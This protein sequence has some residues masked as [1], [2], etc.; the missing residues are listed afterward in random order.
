MVISVFVPW[1]WSAPAF[2]AFLLGSFSLLLPIEQTYKLSREHNLLGGLE[3]THQALVYWKD[4][5]YDDVLNVCCEKSAYDPNR[6]GCQHRPQL[7]MNICRTYRYRTTINKLTNQCT[8]KLCFLL[9]SLIIHTFCSL[10]KL[11]FLIESCV[12]YV[13]PLNLMSYVQSVL[14]L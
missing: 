13:W 12:I 9:F 5:Q 14:L 8:G 2:N 6:G 4:L 10:D 7:N 11:C 1:F 3:G